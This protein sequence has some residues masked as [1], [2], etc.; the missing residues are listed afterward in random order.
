MAALSAGLHSPFRPTYRF[1]LVPRIG[2]FGISTSGNVLRFLRAGKEKCYNLRVT[3]ASIK[4]GIANL[5]Y[6]MHGR[7]LAWYFRKVSHSGVAVPYDWRC[8]PASSSKW[9]DQS[10]VREI[11][12]VVTVSHGARVDP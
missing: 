7:G 3:Q 4:S 8:R 10:H 12:N 1:A 11:M 6:G 2:N 9:A 5:D